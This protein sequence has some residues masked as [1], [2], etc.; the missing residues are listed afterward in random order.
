MKPT[1]PE[2]RNQLPIPELCRE[3]ANGHRRPVLGPLVDLVTDLK[4]IETSEPPS[5][6]TDQSIAIWWDDQ[7]I[8]IEHTVCKTNEFDDIDISVFNGKVLI[9]LGRRSS[10][11]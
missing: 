8:Y 1:D 4:R 9:R 10:H 2:D 5:F 11:H 6:G 3:R 7:N